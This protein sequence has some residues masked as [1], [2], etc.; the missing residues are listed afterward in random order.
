MLPV[1]DLRL[2]AVAV[3][4]SL[5]LGLGL[6]RRPQDRRPVLWAAAAATAAGVAAWLAALGSPDTPTAVAGVSL[7]LGGATVLATVFVAGRR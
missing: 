4:F 7:T 5:L 1:T 6:G 2:V 3:V